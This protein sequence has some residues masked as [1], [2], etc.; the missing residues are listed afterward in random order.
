M[1]FLVCITSFLF[2]INVSQ[3]SIG[4][5]SQIYQRCLDKCQILNCTQDGQSF[6]SQAQPLH[7]KL[8]FWSCLD[9][10]KYD[11]MWITVNGFHQRGYKTPQFYGKWPFLRLL[12]IQ[13]P[14]SFIFSLLNL[15]THLFMLKKFVK[16]VRPDSPLY[17]T[18]FIYCLI[19]SHA[20]VWSAIFH[21]RDVPITEL[22]DYSSAFS[23]V[24]VNCFVMLVRVFRYILSR[25]LFLTM[26]IIF[27]AVFFNHT[28]Y[29]SMGR[30][31][32]EYNMKLNIIIGTLTAG[33]W[34]F[35]STMI[36][37]RQPYVWKCVMYVALTG[38][39]LLLELMDVPPIFYVF[40]C[41]SLWHLA[42]APLVFLIYSFAIDDC[43]Y[44]R[45]IEVETCN[46]KFL[47]I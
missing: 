45:K 10:C 47:T 22:L 34:F 29:L 35:W 12:G 18:W 41:H 25:F 26:T 11:C 23:I 32:Y 39:V 42:T 19:C 31:D 8:T 36:R 20:W 9:E 28:T 6:I 43:N 37:N 1:W 40:D 44:L 7:L 27:L 15:F 2:H 38:L 3:A 5:R 33:C 24:L 21:A 14:A 13:E 4:D 17:W 46:I 30:F 16:S